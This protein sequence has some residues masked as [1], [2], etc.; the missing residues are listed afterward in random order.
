M[1]NASQLFHPVRIGNIA[2]SGNIFLA[3]VAGYS[4][5][6]FRSIC[7]AHGAAF[8]YTEMVSAEALV[9]NSG[10]TELLMRRAPNEKQYAVQ[11]FG[12]NPAYMAEAA[13][14]VLEKTGTECIDI[15]AGCPV[16]KI[17]KTGAGSA[18]TRDP[19][20]LFSVTEAVVKAAGGIP[21]SVKIR[22]G[23]D[24]T[25]CTWKQAAFAALDGGASAITLHPRTRAQG[26]EGKSD[27]TLL[28]ELSGIVHA[29]NPSIPV[30]GS[31]DL[32][33]PEDGKR[34][35]EETGCDGIM[36]A[37]GAMGNPFI[38]AQTRDLLT[39]GSYSEVTAQERMTAAWQELLGLSDLIGEIPAC[40]EMRK[41]FCA[42]SRGI[43]NG[44]AMRASL[45]KAAAIQDYREIL[46]E[47]G[48]SE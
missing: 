47:Y 10:K 29:K 24:E 37:R 11:I 3:P 1:S 21:V 35:L 48:F 39:A 43:Q 42:Y 23:W 28:A 9:R 33:S 13:C 36:F 14:I 22:S 8:T 6:A 2:L 40:R 41:R 7:I 31:G 32:F 4:D 16:P 12:S 34:M 45:V 5:P 15:N 25:Q 20:R 18:L 38:F 30:F 17:V 19:E 44:G 46:A 27:W 26:Y